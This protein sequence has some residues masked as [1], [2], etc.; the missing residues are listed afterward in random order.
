MVRFNSRR[1]FGQ[2]L[3]P[4]G[5]EFHFK[6]ASIAIECVDFLLD[7]IEG[8]SRSFD[9]NLNGPRIFRGKPL[10]GLIQA[11]TSGVECL[12]FL[13]QRCSQP[14]VADFTARLFKIITA[15]SRQPLCGRLIRAQAGQRF[16]KRLHGLFLIQNIALHS[17][18]LA[19]QPLHGLLRVVD[20]KLSIQRIAP[21]LAQA[22][23]LRGD[24]AKLILHSRQAIRCQPLE[25]G[26]MQ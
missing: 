19:V 5:A 18:N 11:L 3:L 2:T 23:A 13:V 15:T 8:A 9:L 12:L 10:P 4:Q 17:G 22:I 16:S 26:R 6:I 24:S 1:F 25:R 7:V 20:F 21:L 14:I